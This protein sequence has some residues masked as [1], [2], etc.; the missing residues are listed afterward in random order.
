MDDFSSDHR[1]KENAVI[2]QTIGDTGIRAGFCFS[3]HA[4]VEFSAARS[5]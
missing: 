5:K 2:C 1:G 4:V 3:R